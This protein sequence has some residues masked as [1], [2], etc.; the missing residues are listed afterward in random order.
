MT[1]ADSSFLVSL[2]IEDKNSRA[3]KDYLVTNPDPVSITTFSRSEALHAI[4][5]L[6]FKKNIDLGEM[7]RALLQFEHDA[8]EGY[9]L[10][11]ELESKTVFE[12]ADQLSNRHAAEVGVRY[13]DMLHVAS[14]LLIGARLFLTFDARQA[15]LANAVGLQVKP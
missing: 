12:K 5:T 2:F 1:Y 11:A 14:A 9:L 8:A 3:A 4:R 15:K 10:L 6:A 7:T 13:L